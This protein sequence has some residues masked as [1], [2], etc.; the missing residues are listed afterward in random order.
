M[1]GPD[2]IIQTVT[3]RDA[4]HLFTSFRWFLAWAVPGLLLPAGLLFLP[5]GS[6]LFWPLAGLGIAL[7]VRRHRPTGP[8]P[9]GLLLGIAAWGFLVAYGNR[10]STPCQGPSATNCHGVPPEP[11]LIAAVGLVA[12]AIVGFA[13]L[14][15][16]L[17][18][19]GSR[20]MRQ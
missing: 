18:R 12:T 6:M 8:E 9:F 10:N 3:S 11:F 16:T 20:A 5:F 13:V 4:Q 15:L 2:S 19:T 1:Y 7:L 14:F 17:G